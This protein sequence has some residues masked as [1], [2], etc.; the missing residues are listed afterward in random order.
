M[1]WP[2][3]ERAVRVHLA[4]LLAPVRVYTERP[5]KPPVSYVTVERVGGASAWIDREV[6]IEVTVVAA[7]RGDMWD[8]A[9]SV[10]TAMAA[11]AAAGTPDGVYVDD[12]TT[13]FGFANDPPADPAK[14]RA[15]ATFTL[16]VRP[17]RA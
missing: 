1:R 9:A 2:N 11:L 12:V 3:A 13:A 16:T 15:T 14:R 6:D 8:L 4:E 17:H 10:E 7:D 5:S